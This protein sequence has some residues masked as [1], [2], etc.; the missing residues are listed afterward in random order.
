MQQDLISIRD[1]SKWISIEL[2]KDI[3]PSNISY[4]INYGRIN[5]YG[6]NGDTFVSK[7][8]I[9][10]YYNSYYE[11]R[12][13]N[14]KEKLGSDIDWHLSFENYKESETTKHVHRLHPSIIKKL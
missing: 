13:D 10:N 1:A 12:S 3:T 7:Q 6:D 9:H 2:K 14:W 4:L 11:S 8:E 5:K